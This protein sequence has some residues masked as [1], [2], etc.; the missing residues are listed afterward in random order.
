MKP[1]AMPVP[2]IPALPRWRI[3][4]AA[5]VIVGAI[6]A[7]YHHSLAG[8]LVFDDEPAILQNSTIR[9]L[10]PVWGTWWPPPNETVTGRPLANFTLAINYAVSG[11]HVWSY[12]AFN[13]LVHLL[14]GLTLFGLV[15][16]TLLRP[17][18]RER[19]GAEALPMALVIALLWSLHPLQVEAVTYVIQ[20]VESLMALFF[21]LVFYCFIRSV[22]SP[23]ARWWQAGAVAAGL[24]GAATKEVTAVAPVLLLFYD[25]TFVAGS[26]REAWRRRRGLYGAM[27][28]TWLLQAGLVASAGWN[29]NGTSGFDVGISPVA[30]WLT[31]FEAVSR[32][33][34]LSVWPHPLIFEYGT[35]WEHRAAV[36]A[37]DALFVV[38]LAVATLVALWRRPVAGFLG[39]W[40]FAILAP[41]SVI[42]GRIQMIVEHRMYLPLAAVIALAVA[43][44]TL[45]C[46]RRGVMACLVLAAGLGGLTERR[47]DDYRSAIALWRDTVVKRPDNAR[48]Y[49][50]LGV[51]LAKDGQLAEAIHTYETAL[52]LRPDYPE[53]H[54]NLGD[55]LTQAG[56]CAAAISELETALRME[57]DYAIAH[58][59]L[60]N[61]LLK[62]GRTAEAI[63]HYQTA[64]RL[65]PDF[66]EAHYDLG[67]ALLAAGRVPEAIESYEQALRLE[68]GYAEAHYNLGNALYTAGRVPEAIAHYQAALRIRPDFVEA[69]SNLGNALLQV[70]RTPEAIVEFEAALRIR[71]DYAE[72]YN[73]LGAAFYHSGRITDAIREFEAALRLK[74][75][76]PDARENLQRMRALVPAAGDRRAPP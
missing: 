19:F 18:L 26:F 6:L 73:N 44:A 24:L 55:A 28:A 15:R 58:S 2:P 47:N 51:V 16:R 53:A 23:R 54:N 64:L 71:P 21:L 48:A 52:R 10:W 4:L 63:A 59:N 62:L 68:P 8:A 41:T 45:R 75:G 40:F 34:W 22:D 11:T 27:A 32:Y 70:D 60:G 31:Q 29:R 50:C 12:H 25:R 20:R 76:Y 13:L 43:G 61:A 65:K 30:Y 74:P 5:A 72:G 7:A 56:R 49:N 33:L 3:A 57:P 17:V 46:G 39:G 9:Q 35:F 69:H 42:P 66:M 1:A 67:N 38:A 14:A 37:P 36:V